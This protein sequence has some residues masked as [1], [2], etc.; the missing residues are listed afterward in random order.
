MKQKIGINNLVSIETLGNVVLQWSNEMKGYE[1][2]QFISPEEAS[3]GRVKV[4]GAQFQL[5][6]EET[7]SVDIS[8]NRTTVVDFESVVGITVTYEHEE[9]FRSIEVLAH[10]VESILSATGILSYY[11]ISSRQSEAA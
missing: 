5:K 1:Y 11:K 8:K 7:L 9:M 6:G 3:Q 2:Q 4:V 10:D